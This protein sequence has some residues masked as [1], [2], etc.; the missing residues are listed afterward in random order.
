MVKV[1]IRLKQ[2][3]PNRSLSGDITNIVILIFFGLFFAL[4]LIYAISNAFKP[5]DEIFLFPPRF[6]VRNP[7]LENFQDLF[8]LMQQSWVP[9]S[10]Y[11]L[12]TVFITVVGTVGHVVVASMAAYVLAKHKFPGRTLFF[13]IVVASLMF[14]YHVT[15]IPS[16]LIMSFLKWIDTYYAIII[17][18]LAYSLG[19]FLMKQ[20][21]EQIPDSLLEAARIDG[22]SEFRVFW[23]IAM[24]TVKP[25]WLTLV[26]FVFQNLWNTTG[27]TYIYS[28]ELKTLP[29]ALQQILAGGIARAGVAAA[30]ALLMMTVP[31]T[32]FIITQSN[33]IQTMTTSGIKE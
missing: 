22:A 24:P 23:Q 27:G 5:L 13:S 4:P 2:R 30:V 7:S 19:L 11:I 15:A 9:F 16:Y 18:Q 26:I 10:R 12:N 20:F 25:A 28:E 3:K 31:I 29:F 21:M 33:I 14:S 8:I 17:P 1:R 6:F 32:L